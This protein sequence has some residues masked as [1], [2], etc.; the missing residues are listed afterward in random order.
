M[1]SNS[2]QQDD[3]STDTGSSG[4]PMASTPVTAFGPDDIELTTVLYINEN[5]CHWP[6]GFKLDIDL[7]NWEEWS[8]KISLKACQRGFTKWLNGSLLQPSATTHANAHRI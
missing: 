3:T 1:D 2:T 4:G 7:D 8:L 5:F 6:S